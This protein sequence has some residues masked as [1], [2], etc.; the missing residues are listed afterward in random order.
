MTFYELAEKALELERQGK[1]IIRLNVGDTNLP[2]PACAVE[3]AASSL[4]GNISSYVSSAGMHELREK[5]AEKEGCEVSNVIV[6]PGSKYT[7]FSLLSILAEK[8]DKIVIPTPTWPAYELICRQLS[9]ETAMV[10]TRMEDNWNFDSM[11]LEESKVLI[12]CNPGNPTST[13]YEQKKIEAAVKEANDRGI[14]VI[15]DEA[16]KDLAFEGIP[17]YEGAIRIRSF[18]KEFNMANW[19]LGYAIAPEEIAKKLNAF[20]QITITCIPP[21]VQRAGIACLENEKEIL[22]GNIS[23]WKNRNAAVQKALENEG[24]RF[25]RPQAGMYIFPTHDKITDADAYAMKLLDKGVAVA[26]GGH[27]GGY[28]TFVRICLGTDEKALEDAVKLMAEAL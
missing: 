11:N 15:I 25:A 21:F 27:F 2:P 7:V 22:E 16:Y 26:P 5:I 28:N 12:I 3:A 13:V 6:N 18:S 24:F 4:K 17:V 8:G 1:K 23:I 20:S 9:L 19:R 10:K 14:H